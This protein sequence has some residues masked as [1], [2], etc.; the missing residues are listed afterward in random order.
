MACGF[1]G[2]NL[3]VNSL[4]LCLSQQAKRGCSLEA[5]EMLNVTANL[6]VAFVREKQFRKISAL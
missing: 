5:C 2:A 4:L 6:A 1:I 3:A